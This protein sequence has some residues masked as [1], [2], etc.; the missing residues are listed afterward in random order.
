MQQVESWGLRTLRVVV[1][2]L[3]GKGYQIP[4]Q[5]AQAMNPQSYGGVPQG[6]GRGGAPGLGMPGMGMR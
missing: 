5:L 3:Q 1:I 4:P 2:K 6:F